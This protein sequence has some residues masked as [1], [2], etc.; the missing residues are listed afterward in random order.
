MMVEKALVCLGRRRAWRGRTY[1]RLMRCCHDTDLVTD[2]RR[3]R[4]MRAQLT[5]CISYRLS[6]MQ[7]S[8]RGFADNHDN[9]VELVNVSY[10]LSK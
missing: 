8:L 7:E 2:R 5:V 10:Y 1:V 4:D 9:Y 3:G 6:D